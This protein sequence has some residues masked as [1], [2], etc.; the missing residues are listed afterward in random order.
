MLPWDTEFKMIQTKKWR[1]VCSAVG[2]KEVHLLQ[3]SACN[4]S[5]VHPLVK[6]NVS[7][8]HRISWKLN[9]PSLT[10]RAAVARSHVMG[11]VFSSKSHGAILVQGVISWHCCTHSK[12]ETLTLCLPWPLSCLLAGRFLEGISHKMGHKLWNVSRRSKAAYSRL[13][14]ARKGSEKMETTKTCSSFPL[15]Q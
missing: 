11:G 2:E 12:T 7:I 3:F 15:Y 1:M 8:C 4:R 13:T 10:E 9:S 6:R 14:V 5:L